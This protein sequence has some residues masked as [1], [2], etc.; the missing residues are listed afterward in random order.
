[1]EK[2]IVSKT[3]IVGWSTK[4]NNQHIRR[5]TNC[6][7]EFE[8]IRALS[9]YNLVANRAK[10]IYCHLSKRIEYEDGSVVV[11]TLYHV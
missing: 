5:T 11:K 10:V 3:W 6:F 1:M 7:G 8:Y 4:Q 9:K 2:N